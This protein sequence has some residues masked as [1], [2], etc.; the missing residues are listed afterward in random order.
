MKGW[1]NR[2]KSAARMYPNTRWKRAGGPEFRNNAKV[3]E[4]HLELG[5]FA[6]EYQVAVR[7]HSG[8]TSDDHALY[9][10]D[11]RLVEIKEQIH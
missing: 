11:Y 3:H 4:G 1:A 6:G 8:S 7:Q 5:T 10:Y 2:I 9:G